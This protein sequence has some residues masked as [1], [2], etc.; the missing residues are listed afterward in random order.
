MENDNCKFD[1]TTIRN[2]IIRYNSDLVYCNCKKCS[3][4]YKLIESIYDNNENTNIIREIN[5]LFIKNMR[6]I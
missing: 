6:N 2:G 1:N 4:F 3:K 5:I